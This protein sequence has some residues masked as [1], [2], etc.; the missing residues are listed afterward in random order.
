MH[1]NETSGIEMTIR[2]A[3]LLATSY[4]SDPN[5]TALVDGM[6]IW[7]CPIYN[8]DGY[9]AG[10]R[11]NAH[12]IDLNRDYP[13]RFTDPIDDPAG[14]EQ[15]TQAFMLFGYA[16][17]FVMGANYHE[18]AL[19]LNYPWDAVSGPPY[20]APDD[21]LFFDFG[22][23]YTSRNPDLWN[24]GFPYG[25][26]R[27]WQWYMIYGGLQDWAYY[28]HN[29][30]HVTL[31]IS[32]VQL[33]PYNQMDTY[34]EH[35]RD[36]MIWWLERAQ[37]GLSG[38]VLDAR[39][40]A[41]LD[42]TVTLLGRAVPNTIPTD[43]DVGDYHRVISPGDYTLAVSVTGY[44]SQTAS[45]T[46]ISTT[47]TVQDFY[48]CPEV[49]WTVSG[50]V[51][52]A[53]TG[54]PLQAAIEFTGSPLIAT[55]NPA[56][57]QYSIEVC[58]STYTMR[59]SAPLHYPEERLVTIDH[60]Q[61]QDFSL[62]P[63]GEIPDLSPSSKGVS[64]NQALPSEVVEYQLRLDNAGI[65]TTAT[66][67]DTLPPQVTWTGYL[68]ATQGT[69]V[70][71]AGQI[72]WQGEVAQSQAVTITYAVS[73]NQCLPAGT[74]ILNLAELNDG[75]TSIITR[76]AQVTVT[77]AVPSAPAVPTPIDGAVD[78]PFNTTLSWTASTDLN[79]DSITYDI[80]FGTSPTPPVVAT[81]LTTPSFTP[82]TLLPGTT[83]YWFVIAHDGLAETPGPTWSFT[84]ST[85]KIFLP[86]A[87]K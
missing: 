10:S 57:G 70:F 66:V 75:V 72:L 52:E 54:L 74:I 44:L 82:G 77:N 33:P 12:G 20:Y 21:Q 37:T 6:E 56:N 46:V 26:T 61:T 11:Y 9:F 4:G 78:Q 51:T 42:G 5:L 15:E 62:I 25:M 67:T 69:P 63:T 43:P 83:Y 29:E 47:A 27:G 50:T 28:W 2:L 60:N 23:G 81:G 79:C 39:N 41:P 40:N 64:A 31:E 18:G 45:V 19:V 8:P 73:L 3:E 85:L 38:L 48:L 22:Y 84:T 35:N 1:G 34:W 30:H 76:T 49:S 53:G 71:D 14:H 58:P 65:T 59:A 16:H 55:T 68:S 36:A 17:R 87:I 13:D 80:A 24:G 7:L 32:E 86:I